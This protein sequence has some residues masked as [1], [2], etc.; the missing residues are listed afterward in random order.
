MCNRGENL[1]VSLKYAVAL[2]DMSRAEQVLLMTQ[3]IFFLNFFISVD[4]QIIHS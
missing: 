2:A 4:I 3:F 1:L